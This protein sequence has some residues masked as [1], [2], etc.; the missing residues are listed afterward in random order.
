[1]SERYIIGI[2]I[3]TTGTKAILF[4]DVGTPIA[5]AYRGYTLSTPAVGRS[6]HDAEGYVTA[7]AETVREVCEGREITD[8]VAAIAFSTQGGTLI[9]VDEDGHPLRPAIVWNDHRCTEEKEDYLREMGDAMTLYEKTGWKLGTGLPL[10]TIRHL[11][12]NEPDVFKKTA[13]FLS[14]PDFVALRLTGKAAIDLSNAGINQLTDI[15]KGAHDKALL[16]FAGIREDQLPEIIPSGNVIAPLSTEGASLLGLSERTLLVS[17]AHDQY[18]VALGAG[19]N[20]AGDI[21]I[22]SGTCWVVT[23]IGN[24]PDFESGLAQSVAAARG[25]WGSLSSLSSGGVCL[26]WLRKN[27]AT[28]NG[29][30]LI[31]FKTLDAEA[32]KRA[33]ATD[34]LFFYPFSG[35][36]EGGRFQKAS[37]TGLDLSHDRFHMA[38]AVMEGVVF[39]ILWFMEAFKTKPSDEGLTLAGGASKSAVWA[40]MLADVSGLP[41]RLPS[42]PDLACVG[43]AILAGVGAGLYSDAR[44]GYRRFA[45]EE[46]IIYPNTEAHEKYKVAFAEYKRQANAIAAK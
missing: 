23:A 38:R 26:E 30:G 9:P 2:D 29:E 13:R 22:G 17:G 15:R 25:L 39:Q 14:V 43:A 35:K 5:H 19:A 7:V 3:G 11:K 44:E 45:A 1:M 24:E 20:R 6:E 12:K 34:G 28:V 8:R 18:A 33:A 46:K 27:V 16:S 40:Q 4:D 10:L 21:L 32:E 36:Y 37:F 42:L 31:D 41:V